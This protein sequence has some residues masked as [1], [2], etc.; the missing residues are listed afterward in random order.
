MSVIF[1]EVFLGFTQDL[2]VNSRL[3]RRLSK[4]QFQSLYVSSF[5]TNRIRVVR[6]ADSVVKQTTMWKEAGY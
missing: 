5:I 4:D 6:D 3:A 1:A 2:Q